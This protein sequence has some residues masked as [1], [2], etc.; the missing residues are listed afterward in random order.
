MKSEQVIQRLIQLCKKEPEVGTFA[1]EAVKKQIP[2]KSVY[3]MSGITACPTCN[4]GVIPFDKHCDNCG[5]MLDWR[6]EE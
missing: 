2:K 3:I 1:I 6:D 4:V 5:Q